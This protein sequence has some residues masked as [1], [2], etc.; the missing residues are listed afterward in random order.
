MKKPVLFDM[1]EREWAYVND[2]YRTMCFQGSPN[3]TYVLTEAHRPVKGEAQKVVCKI[4]SEKNV[5]ELAIIE[6]KMPEMPESPCVSNRN[7]PN[8]D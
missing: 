4:P 7:H 2:D 1:K 6:P 5:Y 8:W 3:V